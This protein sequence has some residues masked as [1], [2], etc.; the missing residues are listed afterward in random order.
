M[1]I[2][3]PRLINNDKFLLYIEDAAMDPPKKRKFAFPPSPPTSSIIDDSNNDRNNDEDKTIHT[4]SHS[5]PSS[6]T[7]GKRRRKQKVTEQLLG[8][9]YEPS[10]RDCIC[11]RGKEA[12]SHVSLHMDESG[13]VTTF[14]F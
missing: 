8:E 12:A 7:S 11:G 4:E 14:R 9:D 1:K 13:A 10:P 3:G 6:R 5:D 2:L